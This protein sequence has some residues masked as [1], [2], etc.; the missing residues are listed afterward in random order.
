[1]FVTC[2]DSNDMDEIGIFLNEAVKGKCEGGWDWRGV[3]G[4]CLMMLWLV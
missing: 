2:L 3:A 4:G 1:M